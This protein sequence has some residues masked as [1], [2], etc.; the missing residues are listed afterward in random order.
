VRLWV[1][2]KIMLYHLH[3]VLSLARVEA[4]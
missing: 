3:K 2:T 4:A 1:A